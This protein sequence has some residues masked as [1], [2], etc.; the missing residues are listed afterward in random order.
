MSG[1]SLFWV[2]LFLVACSKGDSKD[3]DSGQEQSQVQGERTAADELAENPSGDGYIWNTPDLPWPVQLEVNEIAVDSGIVKNYLMPDWNRFFN[4]ENDYDFR[5]PV[6]LEEASRRFLEDPAA[7]FHQLVGDIL[8]LRESEKRWPELDDHNLEHFQEGI[9]STLGET[10]QK[11][12]ERS[13]DGFMA[14]HT[15]RVVRLKMMMRDAM[16]QVGEIP[17]ADI[18]A[19]YEDSLSKV[20]E[21]E[22]LLERGFDLDAA[23]PQIELSLRTQRA[24]K[25]L[26]DWVNEQRKTTRSK[27]TRP[28]G[29]VVEF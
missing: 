2:L 27:V 21:P 9:S 10:W 1:R 24:D 6:Q 13:G 25:I 18:V 8:L 20:D 17:E 3:A 26:Q 28:D 29:S 15:E 16:E 23:R 19:L 12:E 5:D 22:V 7:L 14:A 11:I 4:V